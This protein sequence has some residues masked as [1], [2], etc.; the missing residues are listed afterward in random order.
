MIV[1]LIAELANIHT[2][3]WVESLAARGHEVH[4]ITLPGRAPDPEGGTVHRLRFG[5]PA[6]YWLNVKEVRRLLRRLRPQIVHFHYASGY[7]TLARLVDHH[8]YVLSVW[9]SDVFEFPQRSPWHKTLLTGNLRAA[10]WVCSTSHAMAR[11]V[12]DLCPDL[13]GLSVTPFGVDV[14]CFRPGST[15]VPAGMLTIGTIKHMGKDYGVDTLIHAYARAR[16]MLATNLHPVP[17]LRLVIGGSG[18]ELVRLK[19]LAEREGIGAETSFLGRLPHSG[20]PAALQGMQVFAALS[21]CNES[22]GVSVVEAS[23]CGLPVVVSD[24]GG[25]S[26][27]VD[28]GVTGFVV[29]RENPDRAA[30]ALTRLIC[31]P[32]LRQRFG[33]NGRSRVREHYD[34]NNNV[35]AMEDLYKRL[36]A[37][38]PN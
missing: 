12:R 2:V 33:A 28:S 18:P 3:R 35:N 7:G 19:A 29:P 15:P 34:W 24:T 9:G 37:V 13:K 11:R 22:F 16:R 31:E 14:D 30:V 17:A 1:V 20:V 38:A 6:G 27:V 32:E 10:D 21:R 25:L 36:S 8:P 5:R 26:E 4:L 23:A